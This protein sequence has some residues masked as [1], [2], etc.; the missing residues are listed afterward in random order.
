MTLWV[1][2]KTR[3]EPLLE[4]GPEDSKNAQDLNNS[5]TGD[6]YIRTEILL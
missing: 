2:W 4:L 6:N 1:I 3:I 5:A